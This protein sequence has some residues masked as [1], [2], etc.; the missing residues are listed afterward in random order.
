MENR[1]RIRTENARNNSQLLE[2]I[3]MPCNHKSCVKGGSGQ[4]LRYLSNPAGAWCP[5]ASQSG[6]E[7]VPLQQEANATTKVSPTCNA[8]KV[9]TYARKSGIQRPGV[10]NLLSVN[11]NKKEIKLLFQYVKKVS[12]CQGQSLAI[13]VGKEIFQQPVVAG[14][15]AVEGFGKERENVSTPPALHSLRL[16]LNM[17]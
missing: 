14:T 6:A 3:G 8:N 7:P 1:N 4:G 2:L 12:F 5:N 10:S 15:M 16:K 9:E 17:T 11:S 13:A